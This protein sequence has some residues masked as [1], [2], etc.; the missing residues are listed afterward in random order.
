LIDIERRDAGDCDNDK[1][2][3]GARDTDK[4]FHGIGDVPADP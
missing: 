3:S 1:G 4:P 2:N